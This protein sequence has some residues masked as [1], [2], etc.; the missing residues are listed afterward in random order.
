MTSTVDL[1]RHVI[2]D[3]Y[4]EASSEAG[5]AA[6]GITP[7]RWSLDRAI[8]YL[9][10]ARIL[11]APVG[12]DLGASSP[13]ETALSILAEVVAVHHGHQ[14]GRLHTRDGRIHAVPS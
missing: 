14:G 11:S 12:L 4:W 8:A 5:S 1:H 7:P 6:G 10:E 13:Q 2:P 3:F 9:D